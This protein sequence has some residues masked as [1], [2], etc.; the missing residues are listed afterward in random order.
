MGGGRRAHALNPRLVPLIAHDRAGFGGGGLLRRRR[1]VLL[2]LVRLAVAQPV[3]SALPAGTSGFAPASASIPWSA[4]PTPAICP[5]RS[6]GR[7]STPR[8][9]RRRTS[10]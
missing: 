4:T 8:A 5:P 6:P 9:W 10:P 1:R 3:V 7:P 2:R